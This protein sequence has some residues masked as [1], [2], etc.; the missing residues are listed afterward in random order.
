MTKGLP[1]DGY[2][3]ILFDLDGT[4]L[5]VRDRFFHA[6]NKT[7]KS[8]GASAL[9]WQTFLD[10]FSK[11]TL[12][13]Y[14]PDDDESQRQFL[15]LLLK[16]FASAREHVP[17]RA[18]PGVP[19]A[20]EVLASRG[21]RMSV[22]TGR[23][24]SP[25]SIRQ[26]LDEI[27]SFDY[28]DSIFSHAEGIDLN[29][30]GDPMDVLSKEHLIRRAAQHM[31][32]SLDSC[33]FVGDWTGDIRSAKEAGVGFIVAVLSGG[34]EEDVLRHEGPHLIVPSVADLPSYLP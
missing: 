20:L 25:D 5:E 17:V 32:V 13:A 21:Y 12:T 34:M 10:C 28:F 2:R 18:I 15:Q 23:T 1:P 6:F 7:L 14:L 8:F 29:R 26:E 19:E 16:N 31:G 24:A 30:S 22:V 33:V 27:A 3:A 4:L 11:D 9:D